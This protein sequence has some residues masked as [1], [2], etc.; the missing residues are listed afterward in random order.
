MLP[1]GGMAGCRLLERL[2]WRPFDRPL[3]PAPPF[4]GP[5]FSRPIACI[6]CSEYG[7][8]TTNDPTAPSAGGGTDDIG[9]G[10]AEERKAA[11]ARAFIVASRNS[12]AFELAAAV[13]PPLLSPTGKK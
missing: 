4:A 12:K 7:A 11:S 5:L 2:L 9:A 1:K 8:P 3:P 10:G 13:L 6:S